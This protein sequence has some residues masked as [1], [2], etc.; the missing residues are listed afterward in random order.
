[1][2]P[3]V[4]RSDPAG[5][6]GGVSLA[7]VLAGVTLRLREDGVLLGRSLVAVERGWEAVKPGVIDGARPR[8]AA[9]LEPSG[10]LG[11]GE[12]RRFGALPASLVL[13][14]VWNDMVVVR[15]CNECRWVLNY[16]LKSVS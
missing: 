15:S 4:S 16:D 2:A 5:G 12:K 8:P 3:A 9:V 6:G 10:P 13:S 7:T 14:G 11:D 1:M